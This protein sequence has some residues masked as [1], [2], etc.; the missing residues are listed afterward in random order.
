VADP[1]LACLVGLL[2]HARR[3]NAKVVWLDD[4]ARLAPLVRPFGI[5][6]EFFTSP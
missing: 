1:A 4:P 6:V 5:S 3:Q 2:Q